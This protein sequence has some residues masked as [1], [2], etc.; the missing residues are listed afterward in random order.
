[1]NINLNILLIDEDD[2]IWID[3]GD[4]LCLVEDVR[5]PKYW[6]SKD[7][8]EKWYG[9]LKPYWTDADSLAEFYGWNA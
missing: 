8:V 2:E 3:L 7:Q 9:T 4:M 1:M 6:L 5:K